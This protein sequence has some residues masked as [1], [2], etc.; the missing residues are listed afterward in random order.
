MSVT[1]CTCVVKI[2]FCSVT[3]QVVQEIKGSPMFSFQLDETTNV[4]SCAQLLVFVRYI[5]SGDF[6][7][8]FVFC[9]ELDSTTQSADVMKKMTTFFE[10]AQLE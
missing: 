5:H 7:E 6:K 10:S 2:K 4:S 3:V 8:E 9:T 1:L